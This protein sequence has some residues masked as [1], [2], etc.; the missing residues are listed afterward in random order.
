MWF[1]MIYAGIVSIA[2]CI[3]SP[4]RRY[5]NDPDARYARPDIAFTSGTSGELYY[6]IV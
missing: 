3:F 1:S 2:K 6:S 4:C 5:F